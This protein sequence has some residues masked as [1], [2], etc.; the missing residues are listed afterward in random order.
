[1]VWPTLRFWTAGKQGQPIYTL[2]NAQLRDA[3]DVLSVHTHTGAAGQ[4]DDELSGID[5][6]TL[7]DLAANPSTAGRLQRNGNN[8]VWGAGNYVISNVD[9]VAGV[10]CLRTL[11][12]GAQQAAAGNHA[13]A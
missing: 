10:A 3:L 7:D 1:M 11:G 5:K 9:D 8:L 6:V 12:T 2:L 13:H 4:G